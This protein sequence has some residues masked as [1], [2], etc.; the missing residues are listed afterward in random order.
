MI[1]SSLPRNIWFMR[2]MQQVLNQYNLMILG[3][4]PAESYSLAFFSSFPIQGQLRLLCLRKKGEYPFD[5]MTLC[6]HFREKE[7]ITITADWCVIFVHVSIWRHDLLPRLHMIH[8]K[9]IIMRIII[10]K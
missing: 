2:C 9:Y 8:L 1:A 3:H 4:Y 7:F 5:F 10:W 6:Q